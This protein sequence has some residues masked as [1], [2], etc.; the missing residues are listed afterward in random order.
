MVKWRKMWFQV[1]Y[2][3]TTLMALALACGAGMG[4]D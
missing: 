3:G 1:L 4:W 2:V